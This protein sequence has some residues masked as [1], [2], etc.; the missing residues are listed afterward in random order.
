MSLDSRVAND[1]KMPPSSDELQ[2]HRDVYEAG[3]IFSTGEAL[4]VEEDRR[5][6]RLIDL[7]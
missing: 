5:I 6:L 7:K 3:E 4:T 1:S 2:K